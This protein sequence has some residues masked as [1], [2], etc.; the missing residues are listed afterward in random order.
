MKTRSEIEQ[1]IKELAIA[2]ASRIFLEATELYFESSNIN[3]T[4]FIN[5]C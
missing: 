1:A 2:R 3:E 4:K 5:P